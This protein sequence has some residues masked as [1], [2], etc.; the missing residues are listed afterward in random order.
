MPTLKIAHIREQGQDMIIVPL[1]TSFEHKSQDDQNDAVD[2]I[3]VAAQ[4]A[5]LRGTV[6]VVWTSGGRMRFIGPQ[7]WHPFLRSL[8]MNSIRAS[9]NRT[10][11]W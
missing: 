6:V 9:L 3:Q 7:P 1:D 2:E 8:S 10:L 5:G 11:S 4:S